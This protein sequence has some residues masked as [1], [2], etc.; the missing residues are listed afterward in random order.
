MCGRYVISEDIDLSR[1]EKI[2]SDNY[3]QETL[4]LWKRNGEIFPSDIIMVINNANE[5]VLMH[6]GYLLFNRKIIN[7]RIESIRDKQLYSNDFACHRCLIPASGFY[8]WDSEKRKC[9]F[10][11]SDKIMYL[12]GIYQETDGLPNCSIITRQATSTR[13]IHDR[14]PVVLNRQQAADY[15]NR[16]DIDALLETSPEF[17]I[18]PISGSLL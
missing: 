15:L 11:T 16:A 14:I 6:W 2:L 12:A 17:T 7:T 9:Y 4:R 5:V 18:E 1:F 10:H 3:S 8:E 13:H